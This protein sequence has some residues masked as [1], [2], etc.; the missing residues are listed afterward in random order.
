[1]HA[2][3]QPPVE[4]ATHRA[5]VLVAESV[6]DLME[7]WNF[8]PSLG[9]VWAVLYLSPE[10]LSAEDIEERSG[11]STGNVSMSLTE[12]LGWGAVRRLPLPGR[13]RVFVAETD[14]WSLVARVITERELRLVQRTIDNLEEAASLLDRQRSSDPAAM[15]QN[16]FL[17]TRV[18]NLLDLSRTG[19]RTL[20]R[21]SRT[22]TANFRALREVL[23]PRR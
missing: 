19:H 22:G 15:M 17:A 8:K 5:R 9:K 18:G 14:I 13:K 16:R 6:G 7:F 2:E 12:L 4:D 1:M 21:L 3:V 23:L 10:P 20:E 11:L